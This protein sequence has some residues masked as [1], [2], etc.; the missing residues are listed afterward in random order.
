MKCA[1]KKVS[2]IVIA[3]S[4]AL[5]SLF[6]VAA[7]TIYN[8]NGYSY[9]HLSSTTA[10][11]CGWDNRS[12]E[13]IVPKEILEHY[14]VEIDDSAFENSSITAIDLTKAALL[15]RIGN[16]AFKNCAS[17]SNKVYVPYRVN[18]IGISAFEGCSSLEEI[19]LK[20][21]LLKNVSAQC[22]YKCSLLSN[23]ILPDSL[24]NIEKL[25]FA[26][27]SSLKSI[28]IPKSVTSI[29]SSAFN[30]D[31]GIVIQCY[32]DSYAHQFA[33]ENGID[34]YILDPLKG[35]A[36]NDGTVDISDVTYIQKNLVGMDGFEL[37]KYQKQCAD[38]NA[39]GEV[40]L[41]DATQIQKYLVGLVASL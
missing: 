4:L 13:L 38:V 33:V 37:N 11:L 39:D 5:L 29:N 7:E 32:K 2:V 19:N 18:I 23:V 30:G 21:C 10:S 36:N 3:F 8:Y 15:E 25:A 31:D 6:Q 35:D 34:Y 9:Y 1:K 40:T 17:V 26:N 12:P 24:T 27:C 16:Y 20:N 28:L 41:R 14:F 22:F